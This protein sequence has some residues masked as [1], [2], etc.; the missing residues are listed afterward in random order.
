MDAVRTGIDILNYSSRT[1]GFHVNNPSVCSFLVDK[2]KMDAFVWS[3]FAFAGIL[4]VI[5]AGFAVLSSSKR[6]RQVQIMLSFGLLAFAGTELLIAG[7]S[8]SYKHIA[9]WGGY[10]VTIFGLLY[11]FARATNTRPST[12][13]LTAFLGALAT[14]APALLPLLSDT[15]A[16]YLLTILGTVIFVLTALFQMT[17]VL[18]EE[19]GMVNIVACYWI[20]VVTFYAP[21]VVKWAI[22]YSSP[23]LQNF[24]GWEMTVLAYNILD[25]FAILLSTI[26]IFLFAYFTHFKNYFFFY[27]FVEM[28][29]VR[30]RNY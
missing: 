23:M 12:S 7:S 14:A 1:R 28:P 20:P 29:S 6:M 5:S 26:V 18:Y 27:W 10:A 4:G 19:E 11:A 15:T 30:L 17:R 13:L 2:K 24:L 21:W 3:L 9:R 25:I 16:M 8:G 22:L